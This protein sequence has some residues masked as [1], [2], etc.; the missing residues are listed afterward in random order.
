M[1]SET[2]NVWVR[3]NMW[4]RKKW[5]QDSCQT[6]TGKP[7]YIPA[8]FLPFY[9]R[10]IYGKEK[11]YKHHFTSSSHR[12]WNVWHLKIW[13]N[14]MLTHLTWNLERIR[15]V[16]LRIFSILYVVWIFAFRNGIL[17]E[18]SVVRRYFKPQCH[19]LVWIWKK[20]KRF[21]I[22]RQN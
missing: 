17:G 21:A 20:K 9:H 12:T 6:L 8:I 11:P 3:Y 14:C 7:I 4:Y 2:V 15:T 18:F 22:V 13:V 1:Q 5:G 16:M 19:S 10:R